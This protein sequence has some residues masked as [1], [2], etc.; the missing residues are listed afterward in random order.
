LLG[1]IALAFFPAA[2]VL[3]L[4][5]ERIRLRFEVKLEGA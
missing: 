5:G 4:Y 1:L 3:Q 2:L